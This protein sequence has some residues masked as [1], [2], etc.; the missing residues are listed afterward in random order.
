MSDQIALTLAKNNR[1]LPE[2]VRI[3]RDVGSQIFSAQCERLVSE[4]VFMRLAFQSI[5]VEQ[6]VAERRI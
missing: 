1:A 3:R 4:R 5:A 6:T 2:E